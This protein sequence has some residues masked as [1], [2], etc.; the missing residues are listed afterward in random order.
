MFHS[1]YDVEVI[2]RDVAHIS[3]LTLDPFSSHITQKRG[4]NL[5]VPTSV[6][7][8][9]RRLLFSVVDITLT[10]DCDATTTFAVV[11]PFSNLRPF[12]GCCAC[13]RTHARLPTRSI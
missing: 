9:E 7:L 11:K 4:L 3:V 5:S 13:C 2:L 1:T 6:Y 12:S 8:V 10:P